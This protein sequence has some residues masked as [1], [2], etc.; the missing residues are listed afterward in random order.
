MTAKVTF[1]S[2]NLGAFVGLLAKLRD[3]LIKSRVDELKVYGHDN[4]L[5]LPQELIETILNY[6]DMWLIKS[7]GGHS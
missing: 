5:K 1:A 4:N 7:T 3:C 2:I 6:R